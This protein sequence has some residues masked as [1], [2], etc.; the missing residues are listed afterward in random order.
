MSIIPE[1]LQKDEFRFVLLA[2]DSKIPFEK[3]WTTENNYKYDDNKLLDWISKGNGYGVLCGPGNLVILDVDDLGYLDEIEKI[4]PTTLTIETGSGKRH[5]YFLSSSTEKII[6][7]KD[8]K[9]IG[10]L[11]G[12]GTQC[13]GP[14]SVHPVTKQKYKILNDVP[15][16]ILPESVVFY[17]KSNYVKQ[18]EFE[19]KSPNWNQYRTTTIGEQIDITQLVDLSKMKKSGREFYGVHPVHGSTTGMNFFVNP[20]KGLWHC[21]R[22][23]SGGDALSWLAVKEGI[24]QCSDFAYNGI[25]LKGQKF[26]DT[27]KIAKERFNVNTDEFLRKTSTSV[28]QDYQVTPQMLEQLNLDDL[29]IVYSNGVKDLKIQGIQWLVKDF[30]PMSSIGFS[31]G[32]SGAYKSFSALHMA[33][34]I[35]EGLKVFGRYETTKSKVLY[36]NEENSW[37][38]FKPMVEYV[39][40]GLKCEG[41]D[42]L[43][44]CT[45]QNLSLDIENVAMRAKLEKLIQKEGI[46]VIFFDSLKRFFSFDE[47]DANKVNMFYTYVLKPLARKY[48]LTIIMLHHTKKE[49]NYKNIK[50]DKKDLIRGSSDFVNIADWILHFEKCPQPLM[51]EISQLKCRVAQEFDRKLIKIVADKEAGF[52]FEELTTSETKATDVLQGQCAQDIVKYLTDNNLNKFKVIDLRRVF[53]EKYKKN[54][55]YS[56]VTDMVTQNILNKGEKGLYTINMGHPMWIEVKAGQNVDDIYENNEESNDSEDSEKQL[57][58]EDI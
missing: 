33:F 3:N 31:V 23:Q 46:K 10:E 55:V 34:C 25:K 35:S 58:L 19:V 27:V 24:C 45:Y 47:N 51:F 39:R 21:F 41:S 17:I 50:V 36:L 40:T 37:S 16:A 4:I 7:E 29:E 8:E 43:V 18:R 48:D 26:V 32:R 14:G 11:Q 9:H 56:A 2:K 15:I 1:N 5:Y 42:N 52:S 57:R 44:F 12:T 22:C 30:I 54:M 38:I 13:V 6:L 49:M 28:L 53:E 20:D